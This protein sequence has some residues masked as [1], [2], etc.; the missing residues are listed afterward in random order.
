ML[1]PMNQASTAVIPTENR[2]VAK[3]L[4]EWQ[5]AMSS[6]LNQIGIGNSKATNQQNIQASILSPALVS[7]QGGLIYMTNLIGARSSEDGQIELPSVFLNPMQKNIPL[8]KSDSLID[9]SSRFQEITLPEKETQEESPSTNPTMLTRTITNGKSTPT[10]TDKN[11]STMPANVELEPPESFVESEQPTMNNN[12]HQQPEQRSEEKSSTLSPE[13]KEKMPNN[14]YP[15]SKIFGND[16]TVEGPSQYSALD[17]KKFKRY[18]NMI[19]VH[20]PFISKFSRNPV[21]ATGLYTTLFAD[22][23]VAYIN[24]AWENNLYRY[25]LV[26]VDGL[27]RQLFVRPLYQKTAAETSENLEDIFMHMDMPGQTFLVTDRGKEFESSIWPMLDRWGVMP[28]QVD[29]PHKASLAER[30]IRTLE[31]RLEKYFF[32]KGRRQWYKIL[33]DIANAYN[34]TVHNAIGMKPADVTRDNARQLFDFMEQKR[35][36]IARERKT[37]FDVGDIVRIPFN[38]DKQT[39]FVKG[40]R[41]NWESDFYQI[42]EILFG[43]HV[44]TFFI[45][46]LKTGKRVARRFY[47]KELNLVIKLSEFIDA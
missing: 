34:N 29:G 38:R 16:L 35:N 19:N 18:N 10:S 23:C 3:S 6:Q 37:K 39:T 17:M 30:V 47:E 43:T 26:V 32:K 7:E 33:Q 15:T 46:K 1:I 11:M 14:P 8:R 24:D 12:D 41:A 25:I 5:S 31:E 40:A 4:D 22:I 9:E 44:P 21:I 36:Q 20:Q 28:V 2:N 13:Q 42:D 45:V 27:S